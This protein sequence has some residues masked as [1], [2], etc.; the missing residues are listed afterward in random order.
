LNAVQLRTG[1]GGYLFGNSGHKM[2][3]LLAVST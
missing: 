3:T 1:C 2:K